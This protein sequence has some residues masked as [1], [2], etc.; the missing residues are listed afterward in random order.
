MSNEIT[1]CE[2]EIREALVKKAATMQSEITRQL[3]DA[4]M[5]NIGKYKS[6]V[7]WC[8][9]KRIDSPNTPLEE[10]IVAIGPSFSF[11][12]QSKKRQLIV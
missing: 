8:V 9:N 3:C 1:H 2:N 6:Q 11:R 7:F 5:G 4:I 12:M 10:K